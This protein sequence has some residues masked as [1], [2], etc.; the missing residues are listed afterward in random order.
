M[1]LTD[2]QVDD[3]DRLGRIVAYYQNSGLKVALD[4]AEATS[5]ERVFSMS[6]DMLIVDLA[7]MIEKKRSRPVTRIYCR[8]WNI[9]AISWVLRCCTKISAT[10]VSCV[11]PGS[12]ADVITWGTCSV[13]RRRTG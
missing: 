13:K 10:L 12:T 4:R 6:P 3:F 5:L 2:V 7:S 11:M 8:R 1:T 9:S